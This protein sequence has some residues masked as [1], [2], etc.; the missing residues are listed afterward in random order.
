MTFAVASIYDRQRTGKLV[1]IVVAVIAV[2]IFL[3]VSNNL[4]KQLGQQEKE[5][6][7]IRA[8][9]TERLAKADV[10]ADFEFLLSIISQNNSIPVLVTDSAFNIL[11][12]RNFPLPDKDD[13][14]KFIFSELSDKNKEYLNGRLRKAAGAKP[15][16][17]LALTNQHFI[18][19]EIF[20][21]AH[22]YIYYEDS[23]PCCGGCPCIPY[24]QIVAVVI[25]AIIIYVAVLYTK[26]AETEPR[27]GR[28]LERNSPPAR[29]TDLLA[30]GVDTVP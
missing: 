3:L 16:H 19:V 30:Y 1:F 9:S 8:Q 24:M 11:E 6:M 7:D 14:E 21:G 26:R 10:N 29:H 28:T 27:V 20:G 23:I 15:L 25:L 5:R 13:K 22:Q 17:E 12:H 4:V 18:E 2:I